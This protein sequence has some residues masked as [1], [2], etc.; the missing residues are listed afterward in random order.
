MKLEMATFP[1][2]EVRFGDRTG[3]KNGVLNINKD[4]LVALI[5]EDKRVDSADVDVAY[6]GEQTRIVNIRDVVEPRIKVSG[7]GCVF[8]GILGPIE[9]VGEGRTHRL[10]GVAIIPSAT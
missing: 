8:P 7:P 3:Y 5:S 2:K 9:T 6:P 1:V 10:S 4:E